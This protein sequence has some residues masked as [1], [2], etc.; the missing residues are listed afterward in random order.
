MSLGLYPQGANARPTA[1]EAAGRRLAAE[2]RARNAAGAADETNG[3]IVLLSIGLSNTTQEFSA[4][5]QLANSDREKNPRVTLVDGAQGGW[6]A[7]R[8][9]AGDAPYWATVSDRLRDRKSVV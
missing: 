4:F 7:D 2:V 8:L 3:R 1:H 9:V 5:M 6:S